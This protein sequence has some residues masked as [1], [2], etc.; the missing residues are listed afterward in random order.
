MFR[1]LTVAALVSTLF[2][3]PIVP[4][5]AVSPSP[6]P[7][8]PQ[9]PTPSPTPTQ[10]ENKDAVLDVLKK[11]QIAWNH[12]DIEAF[13]DGYWRSRDT[14]FV[15]GAVVTRGWQTVHDRYKAK[16]PN[17]DKMGELN[18][19]ELEIRMFG[20]DGALAFGRWQLN[21]AGDKPHGWFTLVLRRMPEGWKIVHDHTSS[22]E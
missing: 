20:Y 13:M 3:A 12:G 17:R 6:G 8:R 16:Y 18:F 2:T 5:M 22:A 4:V 10:E 21:R 7:V 1:M 9:T 11:Q 19:S 15:S 14:V